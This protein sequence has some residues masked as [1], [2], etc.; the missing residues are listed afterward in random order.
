MLGVSPFILGEQSRSLFSDDVR[1][2]DLCIKMG[3]YP[4]VYVNNIFVLLFTPS[5]NSTHHPHRPL[6]S[7]KSVGSVAQMIMTLTN[8]P[9]FAAQSTNGCVM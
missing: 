7:T 5:T 6:S 4:Y 3:R 1:H 9:V 2:F 8:M